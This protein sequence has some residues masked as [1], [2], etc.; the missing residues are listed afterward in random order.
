MAVRF[1]WLIHEKE[2]PWVHPGRRRAE[3]FPQQPGP[4][5]RGVLGGT[6]SQ[7]VSER[8]GAGFGGRQTDRAA[9]TDRSWKQTHRS[10]SACLCSAKRHLQSLDQDG[11]N[12]L[13]GNFSIHGLTVRCGKIICLMRTY[14]LQCPSGRL[15]FPSSLQL[16]ELL[17]GI[18]Q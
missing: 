16:Y 15:P 5:E 7:R 1:S 3:V 18:F 14:L 2:P 11:C 8:G 6:R 12:L 9:E 10:A 13:R 4:P 17:R